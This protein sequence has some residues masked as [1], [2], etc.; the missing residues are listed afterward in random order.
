MRGPA[1]AVLDGADAMLTGLGMHPLR[2]RAEMPAHIADRFLEAVWREALWMVR[3]GQATTAE[4]DEAIR[5]GFG[6]R[7]AQMGLFETY[8]IAGGDAGMAHFIGQFGPA[9]SWPWTPP[10]RCARPDRRT[11]R[12]HR[13][14]IGRAIRPPV[15]SGAG[16]RPRRQSGGHPARAEGA[17]PGGGRGGRGP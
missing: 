10:D 9:L 16:T 8:R 4:I 3:D 17:G 6:L 15:H 1:P 11:G 2:V 7:W 5:M 13:R 12:H 14:A